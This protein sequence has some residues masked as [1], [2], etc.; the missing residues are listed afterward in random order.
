MS[1]RLTSAFFLAWVILSPTVILADT[2]NL[3]AQA[4]VTHGKLPINPSPQVKGNQNAL[5]TDMSIEQVIRKQLNDMRD[6]DFSKA[7]YAYMSV[8]FQ[9]AVDLTVFKAFVRKNPTLYR[10]KEF[11]VESTT[12]QDVVAV[13][14]GKLISVEEQLARVQYDLIQENGEW[15]IRKIDL[16]PLSQ[17]TQVF[18]R[19]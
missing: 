11:K 13:V 8:D 15:K 5:E 18:P 12:F 14:K 3:A 2:A 17:P 19:R 16:I 10:N 7:Y 4:P 1:L 9:K 6:L